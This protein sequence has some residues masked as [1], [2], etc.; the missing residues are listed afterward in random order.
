MGH[1]LAD[2]AYLKRR[3]GKGRSGFRWYV[4]VGVPRDFG[5]R[6]RALTI[7]RALN[8]DDA[9]EAKRS[10][11]KVLAEI[12]EGFKHAIGVRRITSADVEHE[13][14]RYLRE[15]LEHITKT[16]EDA[17]TVMT[18][19][20]GTNYKL[21]GD[22]ALLVSTLCRELGNDD[23]STIV[24]K[25]AEVIAADYGIEMTPAQHEELCRALQKAEIE[26]LSRGDLD[27][28]RPSARTSIGIE[29]PCR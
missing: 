12:F 13:A 23:W 10:K 24:L 26:A 20:F 2:T 3:R 14:Q 22:A 28:Q 18:N 21:G 15:R 17:F 11:H 8:T 5:N 4:R 9:D 7:E 19:S 27:S 29:C 16:P 1:D 6:S 25:E